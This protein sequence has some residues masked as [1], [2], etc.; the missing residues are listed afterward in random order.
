VVR[1]YVVVV[2]VV[3][4]DGWTSNP[5]WNWRLDVDVRELQLSR[6]GAAS[7]YLARPAFGAGRIGPALFMWPLI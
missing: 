6:S 4:V 5:S 2:V 1:E 7:S 3:V